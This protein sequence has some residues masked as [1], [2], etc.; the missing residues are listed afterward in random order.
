M[1]RVLRVRAQKRDISLTHIES[2]PSKQDSEH[3]DFYVDCV[4]GA[5]IDA[6][7]SDLQAVSNNVTVLTRSVDAAAAAQT[8]T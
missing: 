5:Q 2:R 3:Y 8:G 1:P 6:A 4:A 7:I